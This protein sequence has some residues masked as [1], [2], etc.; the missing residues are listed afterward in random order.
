MPFL[1]FLQLA[2]SLIGVM[3]TAS[4]A[5]AAKQQADSR[6]REIEEDKKRNE[7]MY[8]QKHNDRMDAYFDDV[9]KNEA[10]LGGATGRD[11]GLDRSFRAFQKKQE[12]T[13]GKDIVR[14][15]RQALFTDD[16]YR[17]QA[18]QVRIEGDAKANYLYLRAVSSGIKAFHDFATYK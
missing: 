3:A 9:N 14:L 15:D 17:R 8:L 13:I 4:A 5:N 1:P 11:I 2:S 6:A 10:L 18:E 7:I 16:K 12:K